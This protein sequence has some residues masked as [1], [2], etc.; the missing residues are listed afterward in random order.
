MNELTPIKNDFFLLQQIIN[1]IS[2]LQKSKSL[3]K[4]FIEVK[5]KIQELQDPDLNI[6]INNYLIDLFIE[7]KISFY[8]PGTKLEEE[9]YEKIK[10]LIK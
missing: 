10:I 8:N 2:R 5:N 7:N 3:I 4:N 1:S 6:R 9:F